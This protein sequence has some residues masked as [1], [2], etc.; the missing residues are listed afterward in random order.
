MDGPTVY[1]R[2][3]NVLRSVYDRRIHTA[4]LLPAAEWFPN[5][6]LFQ[7]AWTDIRDEALAIAREVEAVP[8]FHELMAEQADISANDGRDWRMFILKAYDVG[9]PENRAKCPVIDRL[10]KACP[11]VKTA[12]LSFLAP[13]KHIPCHRGPFR[14]IMR[15]H[16]GLQIPKRADGTPATRMII[17]DEE[18][19]IGDGDTLLWDDTYP[20][21]VMN[22]ADDMRIALLLD[23]WRPHMPLDLR[24]LSSGIIGMA[25]LAV[26]VR[27]MSYQG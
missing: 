27:G 21:E 18:I 2:A 14:G 17:N 11:E 15:Y 5:G 16:L 10:L 22:E 7:D 24:L 9:V 3:T 26:R 12:C 4:H 20:H 25:N 6:A 8:R 23:V 13:H 1:E 19:R